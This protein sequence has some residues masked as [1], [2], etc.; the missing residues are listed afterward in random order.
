MFASWCIS[1]VCFIWIFFSKEKQ[2]KVRR[3]RPHTTTDIQRKLHSLKYRLRTLKQKKKLFQLHFSADP[4]I[5]RW[6]QGSHII[7]SVFGGCA[8][9]LCLFQSNLPYQMSISK[10]PGA[11]GHCRWRGWNSK[12]PSGQEYSCSKS[13][14]ALLRSAGNCLTPAPNTIFDVGGGLEAGVIKMLTVVGLFFL[15]VSYAGILCLAET[16]SFGANWLLS[17]EINVLLRNSLKGLISYYSK[18]DT[19]DISFLTSQG[20]FDDIEPG[21][22]SAKSSW[23]KTISGV[24]VSH[25]I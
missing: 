12:L 13:A 17:L 6:K 7:I 3:S 24:E 14:P 16:I 25:T 19:D 8:R 5:C 11:E 15:P 21:R 2:C 9:L 20:S 10:A 23:W 22:E 4:L 18:L 1:V